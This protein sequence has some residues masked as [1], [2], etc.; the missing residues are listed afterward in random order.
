MYEIDIEGTIAAENDENEY[1]R[2]RHKGVVNL[3]KIEA[4][5]T[6]LFFWD[7]DCGHCKKS[8]PKML[9]FYDDFKDKGV[10]VFARLYQDL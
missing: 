1:Q 3:H 10:E 5:F 7:P 8:M 9:E 6:V 2:W 4:P